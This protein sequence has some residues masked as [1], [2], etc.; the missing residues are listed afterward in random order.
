MAGKWGF[1]RLRCQGA[2]KTRAGSLVWHKHEF[3][4]HQNNI[5]TLAKARATLL[6]RRGSLSY[7]DGRRHTRT[8]I[9]T[10]IPPVLLP[11][12]I[13]VGLLLGLW[14]WKCFWIIVMQNKLLYLS[15]LPPFSRSDE[16]SEYEGECKPIRWRENRIRSLDGTTLAICEGSSSSLESRSPPDVRQKQ[17]SVVICYFQ[18]N[19]GSTPLR[20]PF[21]SQVLKTTASISNS[22]NA[23]NDTHYT[24]VALSYRGYWKSSGRATQSGIELDAQAF[25]KWVSESYSA[26]GTDLQ[27][28][29]WGHSLGSIVASSVLSTHLAN[30]ESDPK[31]AP[32][33][34]LI[35]EA[36]MSNVKDM[37]ISLYP[38]K[39]LPYRYLWPFS[40]NTWCSASAIEKLAQWRDQ[41]GGIVKQGE[42]NY[43]RLEARLLPP[44]LIL[45]AERDE[46]V[47]AHVAD[48]LERHGQRLGLGI[49]RGRVTGA[50]HAEIP[51]NPRG[52]DLLVNFIIDNTNN[53]EN[54]ENWRENV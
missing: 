52:R 18:G 29:L 1:A 6:H 42:S 30:R 48:Q 12:A 32:I 54:Q 13:F 43:P 14:T 39:W 38:Q 23:S 20:L 24:I 35:M 16:I 46:V 22:K 47:P 25:L 40:W 26:P 49:T 2:I 10:S 15:W 3:P 21:L 11:P 5:H 53:I 17:K 27:I 4:Q 44:M 9:T 34:G 28:I 41:S 19:G 45:S 36:P 51:V 33:A 31:L 37:L 7:A 8:L 50:M